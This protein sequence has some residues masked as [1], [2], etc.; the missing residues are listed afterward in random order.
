MAQDFATTVAYY[1][2]IAKAFNQYTA[3]IVVGS[4]FVVMI[5]L[6]VL[7]FRKIIMIEKLNL[8]VER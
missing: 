7:I 8:E 2:F 5:L 3:N 4:E 6:T 1:D